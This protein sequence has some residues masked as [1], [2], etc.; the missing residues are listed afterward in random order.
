MAEACPPVWSQDYST[1]T[2]GPTIAAYLGMAI[3]V[4][5]DDLRAT[6][7]IVDTVQNE[8]KEKIF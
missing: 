2:L 6:A 7:L 3:Q 5:I 8:S 4:Q 1:G